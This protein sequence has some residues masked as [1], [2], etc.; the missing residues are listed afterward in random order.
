MSMITC[1]E[2]GKQISNTASVCPHC[3]AKVNQISI[4]S[5]SSSTSLIIY[6]ALIF[7]GAMICFT[8]L[9]LF[10]NGLDVSKAFI[11]AVIGLAICMFGAY[12]TFKSVSLSAPG[13]ETQ[14][15]S[16]P[17]TAVVF[18]STCGEKNSSGSKYCSNCGASL[19]NTINK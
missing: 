5:D 1:H 13:N 6:G 10:F 18:C 7:I 9:G 16:T 19:P 15:I 11:T 2:C 8:A 17:S 12:R 4:K 3:G 14:T